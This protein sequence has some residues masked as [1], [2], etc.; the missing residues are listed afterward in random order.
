MVLL[1]I[2]VLLE[3]VTFWPTKPGKTE[4]VDTG[5]T[6]AT[7]AEKA[8]APDAKA[9]SAVMMAVGKAVR[10]SAVTTVGDADARRT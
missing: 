1:A 5:G 8:A 10:P 4:T 3:I 9:G 6:D 7:A 2:I